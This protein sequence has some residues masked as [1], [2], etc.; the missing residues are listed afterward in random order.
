MKRLKLNEFGYTKFNDDGSRTS[1]IGDYTQDE[2]VTEWI[3]LDVANVVEPEFTQAELDLQAQEIINQEAQSYLASTD[4]YIVRE[5][6]GGVVC[7]EDI[8]LARQEARSR[9]I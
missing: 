3:D 6:E 9:I 2:E 7:P 8:K 4:W 5:A 1:I